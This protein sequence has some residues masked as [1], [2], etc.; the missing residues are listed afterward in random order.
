[1]KRFGARNDLLSVHELG[2][3]RYVANFL[4][5]VEMIRVA[6]MEERRDRK[7]LHYGQLGADPQ[8]L[9]KVV[10]TIGHD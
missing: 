2:T 9:N 1:L 6:V 4:V 10:L 8:A 3:L 5:G 7:L